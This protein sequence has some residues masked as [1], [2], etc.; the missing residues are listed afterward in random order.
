MIGTYIP[1]PTD[2]FN[3]SVVNHIDFVPCL[4]PPVCNSNGTMTVQVSQGPE[5]PRFFLFKGDIYVSFFSYDNIINSRNR[6]D[7]LH[8]IQ[9]GSYLGYYGTGTNICEPTD[10]GL[11]GRMHVAKVQY[12]SV[13]NK[14]IFASTVPIYQDAFQFED[15]SVVK[16]WLAFSYKDE[17]Y[18]IYQISPEF[19]VLRVS[20]MG[21]TSWNTTVAST[22][23]TP[24]SI[25]KLDT[26][27]SSFSGTS[28]VTRLLPNVIEP[29]QTHPSSSFLSTSS[30][31]SYL[32]ATALEKSKRRS[33][34][35]SSVHGSVNPVLIDSAMSLLQQS[36]FLSIFHTVSD[37][38]DLNYASY[39]FALS[40]TVPFEVIA[41]ST[42]LPLN[43]RG[44][45]SRECGGKEPFGF[46]SGLEVYLDS[47]NHTLVDVGYGVCDV[48]SRRLTIALTDIESDMLTSN[49]V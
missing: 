24:E 1:V 48:S 36:Y 30:H 27:A 4:P 45:S 32:S 9:S 13:H 7:L 40:A 38:S 16:N 2:L 10:D 37:C 23:S 20:H 47:K 3:P 34:V 33:A 6:D 41:M 14:C 17:L 28:A 46:V 8:K 11:V 21:T 29:F 22:S 25:R 19:T 49:M 15:N 26:E 44:L 35:A 31:L 43:L 39:F 18:F 12:H 5:D 42:R